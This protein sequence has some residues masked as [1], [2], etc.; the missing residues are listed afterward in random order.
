VTFDFVVPGLETGAQT[1]EME[2]RNVTG[3]ASFT[4]TEAGETITG[5]TTEAAEVIERLR[6]KLVRIFHFDNATKEW[7]FL[8]PRPEFSR[9]RSL[10][11]FAEGRAYWIR[12]KENHT[13]ELNGRLRTLTCIN[14]GTAQENCWNLIVW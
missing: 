1:V 7:T 12:V 10:H 13:V 5:S 6:D 3:S 8:G 14:P 11:R 9:A 2:V 4:V